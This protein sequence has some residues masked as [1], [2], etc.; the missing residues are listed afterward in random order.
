MAIRLSLRRGYLSTFVSLACLVITGCAT[1]YPPPEPAPW[2]YDQLTKDGC[3]NIKASYRFDDWGR[4]IWGTEGLIP[5]SERKKLRVRKV[6]LNIVEGEL[7]VRGTGGVP[8]SKR[9]NSR[10]Q[11][12]NINEVEP[13]P[14]ELLAPQQNSLEWSFSIPLLKK[15]VFTFAPNPK[16][17]GMSHEITGSGNFPERRIEQVIGCKGGLLIIHTTQFDSMSPV[18]NIARTYETAIKPFGDG[19]LGVTNRRKVAGRTR[20]GAT[21]YGIPSASSIYGIP[22]YGSTEMHD[23][24]DQVGIDEFLIKS[25]VN[26]GQE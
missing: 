9:N 4:L 11:N 20:T 8:E 24:P 25:V 2:L 16:I 21:A 17:G 12:V 7:M 15:R 10:I 13:T 22:G 18:Y 3:P 5:E 6:D 14:S 26:T 1:F 23:V 19:S